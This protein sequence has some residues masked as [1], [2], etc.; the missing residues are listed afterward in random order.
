MSIK[1]PL[2]ITIISILIVLNGSFLFLTGIITFILTSNIPSLLEPSNPILFAFDSNITSF[3]I[4]DPNLLNNIKNFIYFIAGI[5]IIFSLIHFLISYG[6]LKGKSWARTTTI[7][8]SVISI[9]TNIIIILMIGIVSN[10]NSSISNSHSI[11]GGPLLTIVINSII[12]YYLY[13]KKIQVYFN[14]IHGKS[15][16]SSSLDDLR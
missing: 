7:I 16:Y 12:V 11:L 5:I 13:R 9:V 1:R 3:E 8:I 14:Q 2:G 15:S 6:L 4:N 10:I